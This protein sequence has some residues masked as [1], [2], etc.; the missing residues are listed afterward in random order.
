MD[1]ENN[2]AATT[3]QPIN[4]GEDEFVDNAKKIGYKSNDDDRTIDDANPTHT[5]GK[6]LWL[7]AAFHCLVT[8]VVSAKYN[9]YVMYGSYVYKT[10]NQLCSPLSITYLFFLH[11]RGQAFSASHTLHPGW[12]LE[13]PPS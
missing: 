13:A 8:M 2:N 3:E 4:D 6:W 1:E 12:G 11:H 9:A 5:H 10:E 7:H